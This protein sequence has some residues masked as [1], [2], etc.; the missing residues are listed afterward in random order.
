MPTAPCST[1]RSGPAMYPRTVAPNR[2]P[3]RTKDGH[4]AALIY[5]DKHWDAFINAVQPAWNNDLRDPRRRANEIDTVYGL[6]AQ[7]MTG[8]H[9]RRV[10]DA[11]RRARDPGGT[12]QHTR[13]AI[14]QPAS[15]RRRLFE[16]VRTAHGPVRLP[17]VPTW[18][19]RTP[20]PDRRSGPELGA[21]TAECCGTG[22]H[23][24]RQQMK[25]GIGRRGLRDGRERGRAAHANC[26]NW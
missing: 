21:D 13:R 10:A 16:T 1:P 14:R 5:N 11:V 23:R 3:Y 15:Q 8:A 25:V 19:S 26:A 4:I 12:A 22:T 6:M 18:F 7:T 2:R 24:R 9:H 20:G 17:G